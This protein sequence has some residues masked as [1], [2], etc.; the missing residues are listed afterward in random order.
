M[1]A[2]MIAAAVSVLTAAPLAAQTGR[3]YIAGAGGFTVSS[4]TTS[5]QVMGEAGV[6][7]APHVLVFGELGQFHNLQPS[8]VLPA[9]DSTTSLLS[10][11]QGLS[12]VGVARVPAWFSVGGVRY[13]VPIQSHLSPYVLGGIGVARLDPTAQF[14]YASGTL[15]DGS[16]PAP[17]TD[18]TSQLTTAGDFTL[19]SASTAFMF[20]LGGGVAVP[21]ASQWAIDVGYRFSRIDADTRV[22]TQGVTFGVGYRF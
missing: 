13:E 16:T 15:P 22:N 6:R 18:V 11:S 19:P 17:G 7:I 4:D 20:T 3:G 12:V 5:G 2:L 10:A 14:T 21:V 9:V 1:R 8:D